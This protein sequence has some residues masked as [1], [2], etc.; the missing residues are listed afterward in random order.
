MFEVVLF[1]RPTFAGDP[2]PIGKTTNPEI[3]EAVKS[4][5]VTNA[6]RQLAFWE[7]DEGARRIAKG[8]IKRLMEIFDGKPDKLVS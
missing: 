4:E 3:I 2:I 7:L 1:Y 5:L 8:E 6:V